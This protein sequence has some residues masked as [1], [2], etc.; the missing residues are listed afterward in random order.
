MSYANV[1]SIR[2]DEDFAYLPPCGTEKGRRLPCSLFVK[3]SLD[4][5]EILEFFPEVAGYTY[6]KFKSRGIN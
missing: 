5:E 2:L 3:D 4:C 1:S 6:V